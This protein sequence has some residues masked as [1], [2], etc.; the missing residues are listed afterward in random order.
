MIRRYTNWDLRP[1]LA[2]LGSGQ[3]RSLVLNNTLPLLENWKTNCSRRPPEQCSNIAEIKTQICP[4]LTSASVPREY[5]S[6]S[7]ITTRQPP[8]PLPIPNLRTRVTIGV[9]ATLDMLRR[10]GWRAR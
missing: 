3:L 2:Y 6:V 9:K 10:H 7:T 5:L 8:Q 4:R 1:F